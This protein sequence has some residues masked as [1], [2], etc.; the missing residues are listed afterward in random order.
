[1]A[2]ECMPNSGLPMRFFEKPHIDSPKTTQIRTKSQ[3]DTKVGA[4]FYHIWASVSH[5]MC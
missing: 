2:S 5:K 4:F 3:V 1:M